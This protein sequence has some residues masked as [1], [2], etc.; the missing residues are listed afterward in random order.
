MPELF[1]FR[2][3]RYTATSDLSKVTAPPYDV[4]DEDDRAALERSHPQNAVQLILPRHEHG[5]DGYE[6]AARSLNEWEAEGILARD[7]EPSL[8]AYRMRYETA[9]GD[10]RHTLGVIGALGLPDGTGDPDVLPHERTLPKAKSDRLALLQATKANLDPIWGLSLSTGLTDAIGDLDPALTVQAVDGGGTSHELMPLPADRVDAVRAVIRSAAVVIA[11]G[12]HRFDTACT[13][14]AEDPNAP[15]ARA[16]MAFVVE[17]TDDELSVHAIHR[18]VHGGGHARERLAAHPDVEIEA[19]GAGP[20]AL[21]DLRARL[22]ADGALGFVDRDGFALLHLQEEH[23][24]RHLAGVPDVLHGIDAVRFDLGVRPGL[25]DLELSYRD[26]AATCASLVEK[27]GADGAVLLE[28]VSVAQIRA[29]A[30]AGVRMPEKTTFFNPKPRTGMV[31][32]L[33]DS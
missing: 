30:V 8:Y 11:D 22:R 20:D 15:G 9:D 10:P 29:A 6:R 32:R 25:G 31:F 13:Y 23:I 17:L 5:T 21:H 14:R 19:L 7:A 4:I 28:P 16:I 27:G 2:G 33:L 18:L 1:P 3:L 24:E 12:H 26:D